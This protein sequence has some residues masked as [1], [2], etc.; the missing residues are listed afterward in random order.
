MV[1][2]VEVRAPGGTVTSTDTIHSE[3][4]ENI[5]IPWANTKSPTTVHSTCGAHSRR[6]GEVEKGEG[7]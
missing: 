3:M 1:S 5:T 4:H 6:E 2:V 7:G